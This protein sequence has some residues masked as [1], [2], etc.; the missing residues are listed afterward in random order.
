[1]K[2]TNSFEY[3]KGLALQAA[4]RKMEAGK[5]FSDDDKIP[6]SQYNRDGDPETLFSLAL[7]YAHF[8]DDDFNNTCDAILDALQDNFPEY[9]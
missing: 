8:V 3:V 2:T 6:E 9:L 4:K 5:L 7:L 1:M